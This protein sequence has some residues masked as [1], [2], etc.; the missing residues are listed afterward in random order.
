MTHSGTTLFRPLLGILIGVG[1]LCFLSQNAEARKPR[2]KYVILVS[3]DGFRHDYMDMYSAPNI[4]QMAEVGVSTVMIPS[5]PASTFP[6]HYALATGL[7]P[8]HNGIVNNSFWDPTIKEYY[9]MGGVNKNNPVFFL[10]EPIWNTAERQGIISA[11]NYWVGS[12][13]KI[14][15]KYPTYYREYKSD[16]LLS[17]EARTDST[18]ALL[19]KPRKERP[20]LLLLYFDEPDHTGH[21]EGPY[22]E[23]VKEQVARV[24]QMIGRLR[25]GI[26][27]MGL[28]KKVDLIVLSDHGMTEISPERLVS[29][30]KYIKE[31]W[32]EH[33]IYGTPT[34]IFSKDEACRDSILTALRGVE[35]IQVWRKEEI[36]AE[37]GYGSSPRIG[38]IVVAPDLGWQFSDRP[39]RNKGTHGFSPY[40]SEMQTV[41]RAEGPDFRKG[42]KAPTFRN[43]SIYPLICHILGI[44]PSPND[45]DLDEVKGM[46][47]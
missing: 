34:S 35:H 9:S 16:E 43:V 40:D 44:E 5:Y 33:M 27:R 45:G 13:V 18:L 4:A 21:L 26:R 14:Q 7:V 28:R 38:D 22:G 25:A 36:P 42:Y 23:G 24:D 17:Y 32:T 30:S 46:L 29:P 1:L 15:G 31:E 12:D 11:T 19:A 41:F 47:R 37:L 39:P 20:R 10:G 2:A 6:N 8:D 3:M